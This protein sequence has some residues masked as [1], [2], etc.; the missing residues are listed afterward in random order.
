MVPVPAALQ[1][2]G[3]S[4]SVV[5]VEKA[6]EYFAVRCKLGMRW[7]DQAVAFVE[8]RVEGSDDKWP[9]T[10]MRVKLKDVIPWPVQG[11]FLDGQAESFGDDS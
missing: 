2:R 3:E 10:T 5:S 7:K 4:E 8:A 11:E 6:P 1:P 9:V